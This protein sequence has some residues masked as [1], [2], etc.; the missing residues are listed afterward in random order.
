MLTI[1]SETVGDLAIVECAG[2]ITERD[3]ANHLRAAVTSQC[4][5]R[6]IVVDLSEVRVIATFGVDVLVLLQ[7]WAH[8]KKINLKLFNPT[9]FV[10]DSLQ[11]CGSFFAFEF[12]TLQEMMTILGNAQREQGLVA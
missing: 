12:P 7:R 8:E 10:R 1:M 3:S 2:L 6:T 4:W 5:A 11:R 9:G